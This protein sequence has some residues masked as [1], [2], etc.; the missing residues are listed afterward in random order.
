LLIVAV[1]SH[2]KYVRADASPEQIAFTVNIDD[3]HS[4]IYVIDA[5]GSN[6]QQL[7]DGKD[8]SQ[9]GSWSPDGKQI[10]FTSGR[11]GEEEIYIMNADG[12]NVTQLTDHSP[13]AVDPLWSP[14]G[15]YL[16]F[17]LFDGKNTDV[18]LMDLKKKDSVNLTNNP[19]NDFLGS[20]SPDGKHIA[21]WTTR[22]QPMDVYVTDIDLYA[23]VRLTSKLTL[24]DTHP[25]WSPDSKRMAFTG[26][27]PDSTYVD[28][29]IVDI[30]NPN[31]IKLTNDTFALA[32]IW[33]LDGQYIVF[34]SSSQQR[35]SIEKIEVATGKRTILNSNV[36]NCLYLAWSPDGQQI[37]CLS[38]TSVENDIY[39]MDA[40]GNN[41]HQLTFV[42]NVHLAGGVP[43][44]QWRPLSIDVG[45]QVK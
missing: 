10:A 17:D 20:W 19:A 18:Y 44:L 2:S 41:L 32:P 1:T 42:H 38:V 11:S 13:I 33:S 25:T 9:F 6:Q 29:Y 26:S 22:D 40:N 7:T 14:D 39:V 16:A 43:S 35:Q 5:D 34:V 8:V 4:A 37:A 45:K 31:P 30:D 15:Q 3:Q 21:F 27:L 23:P 24:L 28:V 36:K 12:N